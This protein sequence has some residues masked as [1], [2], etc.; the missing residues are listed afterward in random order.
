[1]S[2]NDEAWHSHTLPKEEKKNINPATHPLWKKQKKYKSYNTPFEFC[3]HQNFP[4]ETS[5]FCYIKKY[6]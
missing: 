6:R 5:N 1:M 4:P 2:Y 3:C